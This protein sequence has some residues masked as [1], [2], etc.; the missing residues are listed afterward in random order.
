MKTC[1]KCGAAFS[2]RRCMECHKAISSAYTRNNK[3]KVR[4]A[5]VAFRKANAARLSAIAKEF[6]DK[7]KS[8][9]KARKAVY[10][11]ANS[12]KIVAKVRAWRD[13]NPDAKRIQSHN[14]RQ[15]KRDAPGVLSRNVADKLYALQ[16]GRCACCS[17]PL[18][19]DYHIDHIM[20]LYLG[21]ANDDANAQLLT[22]LCNLRKNAAHPID[23]M[24]S[25][26]YLL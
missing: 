18:L 1:I 5:G 17:A 7:N 10:A 24:Q 20:P 11:A 14:Y 2:G 12:S 22:R 4:E 16:R 21:G 19:D 13:A 23:Y 8:A 15:R 6:R 9:I 26:G 3:E 25:K